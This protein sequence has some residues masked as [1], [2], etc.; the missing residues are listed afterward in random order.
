MSGS[1]RFRTRPISLLACTNVSAWNK[2]L[3]IGS[4]RL[5]LVHRITEL[6]LAELSLDLVR[7]ETGV[8]LHGG[9]SLNAPDRYSKALEDPFSLLATPVTDIEQLKAILHRPCFY[10][11]GLSRA[12][13]KV[14]TG[15][16][17]MFETEL[18]S[19]AATEIIRSRPNWFE[20]A[21]HPDHWTKK[22][23][24]SK[25]GKDKYGALALEEAVRPITFLQV[26]RIL[27]AH[28]AVIAKEFEDKGGLESPEAKA[29]ILKVYQAIAVVPAVYTIVGMKQIVADLKALQPRAV[30]IV[31]DKFSQTT[32]RDALF[33]RYWIKAKKRKEYYKKKEAAQARAEETGTAFVS[34][35]LLLLEG[36]RDRLGT[37]LPTAIRMSEALME[38][39]D[40]GI[41]TLQGD[42]GQFIDCSDITSKGAYMYEPMTFPRFLG[43]R[44]RILP[45]SL[46]NEFP[47]PQPEEAPAED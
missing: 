46:L 12:Q 16:A 17:A 43:S 5:S 22:T 40:A 44:C 2:S 18:L 1:E 4:I 14:G 27:A 7:D 6:F 32:D 45:L 21:D 25:V 47:K 30:E 3:P 15:G 24:D 31:S 29:R 23:G 13:S 36:M 41:I 39:S 9:A 34:E 26:L 20:L 28:E 33:E 37:T 11:D 42:A 10:I 8:Q 38:L 35:I 19:D